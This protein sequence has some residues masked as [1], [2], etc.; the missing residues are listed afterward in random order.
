LADFSYKDK[1]KDAIKQRIIAE[2]I[3]KAL[4]N[5][6]FDYV[7]VIR[8]DLIDSRHLKILK[9]CSNHHFIGYQWNGIERFPKTL[10]SVDL[11]D[12]FFVFDPEDLSNRTTETT[13]FKAVPISIL[14]C[15]PQNPS[16]TQ[17]LLPTL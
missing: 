7:L 10:S 3:S 1:A 13:S 12:H 14:T 2:E 4:Q 17:V 15:T 16:Y 5:N 8:P 6:T 11:F 9:A